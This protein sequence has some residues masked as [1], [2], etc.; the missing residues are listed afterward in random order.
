M[1]AQTIGRYEVIAT[2]ARGGM[3]VVYKAKDPLIDRV[4]AVKTLGFGLSPIE[5]EAFRKRFAR[6]AKSAGRLSHPNIVTIHDMGESEDG[7]YIA[8]EFLE[9]RTL[10]DILDSG[11]VMQPKTVAEIAIQVAEGLAFA[12]LHEVVHC[13]VKPA[14]IMVLENGNVKI[15]DFG[16]ARLPTGSRTFAGNVLGSPRYISPEQIVGREIDAR[17][18]IFSLGAVLYEMLTGVP[19]FAGTAIDEILYQVINDKPQAPSVRNKS[20]PP[21]FDAI[22]ERAMAK[23]PGDRYPR[24]QDLA[25]AL[26]NVE[27]GMSDAPPSLPPIAA[28]G[29]KPKVGDATVDLQARASTSAEATSRIRMRRK[30][31]LYAVPAAFLLTGAGFLL[32]RPNDDA[33]RHPVAEVATSTADTVSRA[34]MQEASTPSPKPA[35]IPPLDARG[36]LVR[37]PA[38][39]IEPNTV[40][41]ASNIAADASIVLAQD[42]VGRVGFAISPWGEIYVDGVKRGVTPPM[43]ELRLP[44]GTYQVEVR[45]TTFSPY[46]RRIEVAADTNLRIKHKFR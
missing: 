10:R 43:T 34:P 15:M 23:H 7:V 40:P 41:A 3:G 14:N 27:L 30:L 1:R 8:M 11:V 31:A 32:L 16:I 20:L 2:L 29:S 13:D 25:Q 33:G 6:E 45:N 24:A 5:A 12:H 35:I 36:P 26:R 21:A 38:P 46:T 28:A 44:P 18:D 37:S 39:P 22:V 17:S 19:P 9:G 42:A 4:V